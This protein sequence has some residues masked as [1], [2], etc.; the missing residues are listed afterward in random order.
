MPNVSAG[1]CFKNDA[2]RLEE[3][4]FYGLKDRKRL[5]WEEDDEKW[6]KKTSSGWK[7][8]IKWKGSS[9]TINGET[10]DKWV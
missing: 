2:V 7:E 9:H 10:S 1:W 5:R 8:C 4:V 6:C 3:S